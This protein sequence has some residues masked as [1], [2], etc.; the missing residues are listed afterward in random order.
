MASVLRCAILSVQLCMTGGGDGG[1]CVCVCMCVHV[2]VSV[3][4]CVLGLQG[5][6]RMTDVL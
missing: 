4:V 6:F 3:C 5:R 1:V 2:C